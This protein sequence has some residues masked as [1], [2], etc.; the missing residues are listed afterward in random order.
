MTLFG[1]LFAWSCSAPPTQRVDQ[2]E[3]FTPAELEPCEIELSLLSTSEASSNPMHYVT[4]VAP[5]EVQAPL[6]TAYAERDATREP[7]PLVTTSAK[8][9]PNLEPRSEPKPLLSIELPKLQAS[10][11]NT[12]SGD[13]YLTLGTGI[14]DPEKEPSWTSAAVYPIEGSQRELPAMRITGQNTR[15]E[16]LIQVA[17]GFFWWPTNDCCLSLVLPVGMTDDAPDWSVLLAL[18]Y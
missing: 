2:L 4:S 1:G 14:V 9:K 17:P 16:E 12:A 8:R 5:F 7:L 6:G 13:F 15:A 3:L 18:R 11:G 10:L